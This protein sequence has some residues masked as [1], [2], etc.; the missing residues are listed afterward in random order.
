MHFTKL[1]D[2]KTLLSFTCCYTFDYFIENLPKSNCVLTLDE[3]FYLPWIK[4]VLATADKL[5]LR[6]TAT[7]DCVTGL[8][9]CIDI[10]FT[11]LDGSLRGFSCDLV[12]AV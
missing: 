5:I 7:S 1:I 8:T 12:A 4:V 3:T 11:K 9:M 6:F 10:P 2:I